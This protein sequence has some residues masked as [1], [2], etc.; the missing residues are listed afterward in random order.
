M[1]SSGIADKKRFITN[2]YE[3]M[4]TAFCSQI[5]SG[6]VT[7]LSS[8]L[9]IAQWSDEIIKTFERRVIG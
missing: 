2:Q 9:R 5:E 7:D 4:I 6:S 1:D 3:R 8:S